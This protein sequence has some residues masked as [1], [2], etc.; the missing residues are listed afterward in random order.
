M[1][2]EGQEQEQE[3]EEEE[4]EQ[5]GEML[6][7]EQAAATIQ[8]QSGYRGRSARRQ[9]AKELECG[10]AMAVQATYRAHVARRATTAHAMLVSAAVMKVQAAYRNRRAQDLAMY[11][12][13][14]GST[15]NLSDEH[16]LYGEGVAT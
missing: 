14:Y 16:R 1:G 4:E 15:T 10:A 6:K 7:A 11:V 9:L 2:E 5:E 3:E 12:T 8:L 13:A